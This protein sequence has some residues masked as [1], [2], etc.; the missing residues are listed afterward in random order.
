[1]MEGLGAGVPMVAM[2]QWSDHT[3][4]AKYISR[5]CGRSAYVCARTREE[6]WGRRRSR[7]A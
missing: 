6:W 1:M 5:T 3:M 7:G 2:P 4:N